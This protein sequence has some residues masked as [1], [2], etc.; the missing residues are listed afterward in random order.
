MSKVQLYRDQQGSI[1]MAA[2]FKEGEENEVT[3]VVEAWF[4]KEVEAVSSFLMGEIDPTPANPEDLRRSGYSFALA[5]H[6]NDSSKHMEVRPNDFVMVALD[7][8]F[9]AVLNPDTFALLYT[10]ID[11]PFED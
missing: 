2:Q 3:N 9:A 11:S 1:V 10:A 7:K 6:Q 4:P 8:S 5:A